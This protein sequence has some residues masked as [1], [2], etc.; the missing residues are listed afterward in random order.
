VEPNLTFGARAC[1]IRARRRLRQ[2]SY[3]GASSRLAPAASRGNPLSDS[4]VRLDPLVIPIVRLGAP[5][6]AYGLMLL[7]C[8]GA[9]PGAIVLA[10][11]RL[12]ISFNLDVFGASAILLVR[13]I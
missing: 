1:T 6:L 4:S 7:V 8:L 12:L 3:P 2:Q 13:L 5:V 11:L 9:R 10:L